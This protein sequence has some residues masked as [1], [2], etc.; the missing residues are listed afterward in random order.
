MRQAKIPRF[1]KRQK[2]FKKKF[3][4]DFQ[5]QTKIGKKDETSKF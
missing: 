4:V 5:K 2:N 3:K 1:R